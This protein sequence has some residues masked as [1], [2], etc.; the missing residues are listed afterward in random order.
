MPEQELTKQSILDQTRRDWQRL[1]GI[2]ARFDGAALSAPHPPDGWS[3]AD[4]IGHIAAWEGRM[5]R[6]IQT[7]FRGE[8]LHIPEIAS[9]DAIHRANA[10]SLEANRARPLDAL[11]AEFSGNHAQLLEAIERVPDDAAD[12]WWTLWDGVDVPFWKLAA[13]NT[14]EHYR[15]HLEELEKWAGAADE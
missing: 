1:N 11:R 10:E 3:V 6:W 13:A 4:V 8:A 12:P 2:L 5:L 15:E 7:A 9:W 14:Y